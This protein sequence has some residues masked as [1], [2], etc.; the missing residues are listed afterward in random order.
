MSLGL[1]AFIIAMLVTTVYFV[2]KGIKKLD[3][4]NVEK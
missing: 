1:Y 2:L 3:E 4:G